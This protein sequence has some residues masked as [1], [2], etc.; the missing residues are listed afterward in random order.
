MEQ[1]PPGAIGQLGSLLG[2]DAGTTERAAA[3]AVPALLSALTDVAS[4]DDGVKKLTSAMSSLDTN[5]LS[6]I[7]Q[8]L[9][10][11]A[12]SIYGKGSSL[13]SSLF[14]D[15]MVS[16]LATTLSRLTGVN[17]GIVKNLLA[18]LMPL[19][20]G[21]V[22]SQWT[23]QGGT[24]QALKSIFA[25]L[26]ANIEAAVPAGFSLADIP[27]AGDFSA[28][29]YQKVYKRDVKRPVAKSPASWLVPL[30]LAIVGGFL[31][32]NY[33]PRP[34][35]TEVIAQQSP[36]VVDKVTVMKP[37]MPEIL[38]ISSLATMRTELDGLFKRLDTS[39]SG[40]RD[41]A[42]AERAMPALRE[43]NTKIE[44][45]SQLL[46]RLPEATQATLRPALNE[47]AK[48]ITEKAI[49]ANSV[50]GISDNIK[51]LIQEIV[52]KITKWT[53]SEVQ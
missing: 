44:Q 16:G 27:S 20:L 42:T 22:A 3:A 50:E 36:K 49:A 24:N 1:L 15:N 33:F 32:W 31:L 7:N 12:N 34:K 17:S 21:K 18:Y 51:A 19:I 14:G 43:L 30:A 35:G 45:M 26:R 53:S 38:E 23:S 41:A 37:V 29:A 11:E 48:A 46:S 9:G 6:N 39:L 25:E 47:Q 8:M 28:S 2:T 13:L 4:N 10:G 40:I 5:P 52:A